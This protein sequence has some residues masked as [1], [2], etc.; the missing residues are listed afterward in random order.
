M[1][2]LAGSSAAPELCATAHAPREREAGGKGFSFLSSKC[3]EALSDPV[4]NARL[5][6]LAGIVGGELQVLGGGADIAWHIV[7]GRDSFFIPPHLALYSGI[8]LV[9][10]AAAIGLLTAVAQPGLRRGGLRSR[11]AQVWALRPLRAVL[12]A[13]AVQL[14]A[15][16]FD[17]LWH[18]LYGKETSVWSP[19]H[20]MLIYGAAASFLALATVELRARRLEAPHG[21]GKLNSWAFVLLLGLAL[22]ISLATIAES[23]FLGI[24]PTHVSQRR[25]QLIYPLTALATAIVAFVPAARLGQGR[26]GATRVAVVYTGLVLLMVLTVHAVRLGAARPLGPAPL[27]VLALAL[28]LALPWLEHRGWGA[29]RAAALAAAIAAPVYFVIAAPYVHFVLGWRKLSFADGVLG[30][31]LSL[32]VA[33]LAGLAGAA[34]ARLLD[35]LAAVDAPSVMFPARVAGAS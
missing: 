35:R 32:P 22:T 3:R 13:A 5:M 6:V 4:R 10:L 8:L 28:D 1:S 21:A 27:L 30:V 19:P 26:L 20:F 18:R 34:L 7:I 17:E 12:L 2:T 24:P 23:G 29:Y 14:S 11:T 25:P 33:A 31:L 9:M 16:P 15:G